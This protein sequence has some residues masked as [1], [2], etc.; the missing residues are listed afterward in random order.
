MELC[1]E[2]LLSVKGVISITFEFA[3]GRVI[4]RTKG[5]LFP[6]VR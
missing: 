5:D 3:N 2:V 4:L 6:E 1:R